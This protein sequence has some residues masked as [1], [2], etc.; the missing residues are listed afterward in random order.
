[1]TA[2]PSSG[3][4][5]VLVDPTTRVAAGRGGGGESGVKCPGH[6]TLADGM[7]GNQTQVNLNFVDNAN[8]DEQDVL[9]FTLFGV[10]NELL[11]DIRYSRMPG[12]PFTESTVAHNTVAVNRKDQARG[13]SQEPATRGTSS[14]AV[15]CCCSNPT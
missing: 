10:T 3:I 12:R 11:G 5:D 6:L 15:T 7:N 4:F 13:N 1:L 14:P 2:V 9:T 8:H